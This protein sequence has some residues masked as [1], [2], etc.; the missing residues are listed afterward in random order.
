MHHVL[1][2]Q[3]HQG[4]HPWHTCNLQQHAKVLL[5]ACAGNIFPGINGAPVNA[6][7]STPLN[8]TVGNGTLLNGT[9]GNGTLL[10]GTLS[11]STLESGALLNASLPNSTFLNSTLVNGTLLNDT[12]ANGTLLGNGTLASGLLGGV[13]QGVNATLLPSLTAAQGGNIT[14]PILSA[15]QERGGL[16]A[17]QE[18]TGGLAGAILNRLGG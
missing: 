9:L 14:G 4:Y 11:N 16:S 1:P 8:E 10:N 12:S 2:P 17:A 13:T 6:A 15:V 5:A 3:G 18:R 7:I